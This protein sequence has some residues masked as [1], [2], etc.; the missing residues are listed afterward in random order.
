MGGKV[1]ILDWRSGKASPW[2]GRREPRSGRRAIQAQ[3]CPE[4]EMARQV[5]KGNGVT[6]AGSGDPSGATCSTFIKGVVHRGCVS[7]TSQAEPYALYVAKMNTWFLQQTINTPK[8]PTRGLWCWLCGRPLAPSIP[9]H[10]AL[11]RWHGDSA[12]YT[13][14]APAAK[15]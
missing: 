7:F 8:L 4:V 3:E 12:N 2:M 1:A 13:S 11:G 5:R 9:L 14:P 6:V 15:L 10:S